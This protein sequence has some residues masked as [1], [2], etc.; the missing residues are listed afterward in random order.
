MAVPIHILRDGNRLLIGNDGGGR[1]PGPLDDG[2]QSVLTDMLAYEEQRMLQGR[3][4][5]EALRYGQPPVVTQRWYCSDL[6]L[7]HRLR[8]AYGFY[9]RIAHHLGTL[10]CPIRLQPVRV[11]PKP[12]IFEPRW[13]RVYDGGTIYRHK[14]EEML[15]QVFANDNGRISCP[16]GWG[17]S[18]CI[19]RIARALPEAKIAVV[20]KRVPV[21]KNRIYP[22]LCGILP[23]VGIYGGGMRRTGYRVMCYTTASLH[24]CPDDVD[25]MFVDECHEAAADNAAYMLGQFW[26]TRMYGLSATHDMRWDGK[27][28]RCEGLFGPIRLVVTYPEAVAAGMIVPIEVRWKNVHMDHDPADVMGLPVE[29]KRH[30]LWRNDYRNSLIA[31]DAYSY[32]TETQVLVT[33]ETIEHVL[34]LKRHMPDAVAI[35]HENGISGTDREYYENTGLMDGGSEVMTPALKES[36]INRFVNGE[37]SIFVASTVLNV[38]IDCKYLQV[39]ARADGGASSINSTQIPGRTSRTNERGK[40]LGI[41]HDYFDQFHRTFGRNGARR[42]RDYEKNGWTNVMTPLLRA[43]MEEA[44]ALAADENARF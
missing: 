38:G 9:D 22:E 41:I 34:A 18:F 7:N 20:T 16:P 32:D 17:K 39:L 15:L 6:D 4:L 37:P 5:A 23:S 8:T 26:R 36:R 2:L 10:G 28:M 25:M 43:N 35:Y 11:H 30:G 1:E 31:D 12:H 27:D 21:L 24:H 19:G 42:Y 13:D 14:Q 3:E 29:K 40:R 44:L 33:C